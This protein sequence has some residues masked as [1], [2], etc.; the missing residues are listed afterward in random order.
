MVKSVAV[1]AVIAAGTL[2]VAAPVRAD[3]HNEM[4]C[5]EMFDE[6]QDMITGMPQSPSKRIEMFRMAIA[7]Y[8]ACEMGEMEAARSVFDA[9][10]GR[11]GN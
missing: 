9:V 6:A 7:G 8:E 4:N 2:A 10:F 3:D 1:A 11:V 5:V